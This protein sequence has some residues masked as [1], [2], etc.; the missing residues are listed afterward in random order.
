MVKIMFSQYGTRFPIQAGEIKEG[1]KMFQERRLTS[2]RYL[3][4]DEI[5]EQKIKQ[6]KEYNDL[7]LKKKELESK[8]NKLL[9][10]IFNDI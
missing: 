8:M 1:A 6:A 10:E 7:Y 9:T 2:Y 3:L 5:T 4:G